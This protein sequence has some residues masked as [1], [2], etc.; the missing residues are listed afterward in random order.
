MKISL[1]RLTSSPQ[2]SRTPLQRMKISRPSRQTKGP[3]LIC[4]CKGS[5]LFLFLQVFLK[6][7]R[8]KVLFSCFLTLLRPFYVYFFTSIILHVISN[9]ITTLLAIE[10]GYS[11]FTGHVLIS[12]CLSLAGLALTAYFSHKL[13]MKFSRQ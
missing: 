7:N 2:E 11:V 1:K 3:C 10:L 13:Y 5:V 4:G 12:I 9:S 8:K 6:K